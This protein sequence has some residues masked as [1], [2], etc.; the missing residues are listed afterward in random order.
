[1]NRC[2]HFALCW[3]LGSSAWL[4][5]CQPAANQAAI[6]PLPPGVVPVRIAKT[7]VGFQLLRGGQ[8]YYIKGVA[9]LQQLDRVRA[10]GGNSLRIY[11]TNYADAI[12]NRAQAHNLTVM[13]GLW[14][15][16]EYEDFDYFDRQAVARQQQEIRQ[17]VLRF[18]RHP[19]LLMW[20]VGNELDNHTTNP[21]A[22]QALNEVVRMIHELDPYHPVTTTLTS[23]FTMVGAVRTFCPD[24]DVL[25]INIFGQL[26]QLDAKLASEGW[27]GPY[28]VGEFGARGWWEAPKTLWHA[29]LDQSSSRKAAFM[30]TRYKA[31]VQGHRGQ[32]LGAYVLYWGQR[33]EQTAMWFSLFTP[34][35]EKTAMVDMMHYLW[36]GKT[37]PNQAPELAH[38]QLAGQPAIRSTCL[39]PGATYTASVDASDPE[40]DA[41]RIRWEVVPDVD[42]NYRLPQERTAPEPLPNLIRPLAG[43][44]VRVR[45]P[46]RRGAYRLLVTAHDGHGS[47]ATHSYPFYVGK[48]TADVL[49]PPIGSFRKKR[50]GSQ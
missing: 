21:R 24:L 27:P 48:L 31:S 15:K 16:P 46:A 29:P 19:A 22:F 13:L 1:M 2:L 35:G 26:G 33:F 36:T 50:L 42:E 34:A 4:S 3:L 10:L 41:L 8:P 6:A 32:C 28:I 47:V 40:G 9:G 37:V 49:K 38:L 17:Q 7:P 14:M 12:L 18:R 11:T 25:T 5:A 39:Q 44:R 43:P 23:N 45:A 20:N 30:R